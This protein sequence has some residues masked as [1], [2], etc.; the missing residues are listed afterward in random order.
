LRSAAI[1]TKT[2]NCGAPN[3]C[4]EMQIL[5][6]SNAS[7][8]FRQD[9]P[10]LSI[11]VVLTFGIH[12]FKLHSRRRVFE[13]LD[14]CQMICTRCFGSLIVIMGSLWVVICGLG[15][16]QLCNYFLSSD[17]VLRAI[18]NFCD[19]SF[20]LKRF[21]IYCRISFCPFDRHLFPLSHL[22]KEWKSPSM[23]FIFVIS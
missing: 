12:T 7:K 19:G 1:L 16:E 20:E 3:Y 6:E 4:V 10:W 23:E 2:I 13:V 17:D 5:D 15:C 21:D 8:P 11:I 18:F 9:F 14:A 22:L